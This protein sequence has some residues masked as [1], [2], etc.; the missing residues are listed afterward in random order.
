MFYWLIEAG[1]KI[2]TPIQVQIMQ[3]CSV[4][5]IEPDPSLSGFNQLKQN[6]QRIMQD[7]LGEFL[8]LKSN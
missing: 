7:I 4:V 8:K 5:T 2:N 6:E 1:F 3:G